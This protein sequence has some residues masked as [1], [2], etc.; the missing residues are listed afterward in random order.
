V[1]GERVERERLRSFADK[2]RACEGLCQR[3][4]GLPGSDGDRAA[5]W[6]SGC[7]VSGC[8]Q[9]LVPASGRF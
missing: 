4:R 9:A 5:R 6:P 2:Q 7:A 1:R 3:G 8:S